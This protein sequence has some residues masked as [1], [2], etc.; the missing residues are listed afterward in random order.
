MS[1]LQLKEEPA[2][3]DWTGCTC[4]TNISW[5]E[6]SWWTRSTSPAWPR[7]AFLLQRITLLAPRRRDVCT[8][9]LRL[10]NENRGLWS[11]RRSLPP[12]LRWGRC[13]AWSWAQTKKWLVKGIIENKH[14]G[15]SFKISSTWLEVRKVCG[16]ISCSRFLAA[17]ERRT[18]FKEVSDTLHYG[19]IPIL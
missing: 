10:A 6:T 3:G 17:C 19:S 9:Y 2:P 15:N 16:T 18:V 4:W 11:P 7:P 8:R 14:H 5:C 12:V 13:V 1:W